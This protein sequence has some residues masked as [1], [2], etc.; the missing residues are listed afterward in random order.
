MTYCLGHWFDH[1]NLLPARLWR[2]LMRW[3]N[4]IMAW[5]VLWLVCFSRVPAILTAQELP[6]APTVTTLSGHP[7]GP[8]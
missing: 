4:V 3:Y 7:A 5:T 2:S 8:S 6:G 1:V